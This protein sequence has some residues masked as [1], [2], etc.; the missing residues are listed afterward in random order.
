MVSV[1]V[2]NIINF[3][4]RKKRKPAHTVFIG[5][6]P[7]GLVPKVSSKRFEPAGTRLGVKAASKSPAA[8]TGVRPATVAGDCWG[9]SLEVPGHKM[10]N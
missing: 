7:K 4:S 1:S 5:G 10:G 2:F 8:G 9:A 3:K 6:A